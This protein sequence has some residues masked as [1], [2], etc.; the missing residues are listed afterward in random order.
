MDMQ[1]GAASTDGV[2]SGVRVLD[3]SQMLAGP[4]CGMRLGDM[5][6]DVIKIEPPGAG[7][8]TRTHSFA[9]AEINGHTTA[10]LG[11]NRNKRSVA[12]NLK[13]PRGQEILHDLVRHSDVFIQNFRVG[14]AERLGVGYEQLKAVNPKLIYGQI[15]G[16]GEEG[17]YRDRPGQDLIVQGYSGSMFS[18]GSSDYPP[19]PGA[20]WAVDT[21]AGYQMGMGIVAALLHRERSQSGQK[22]SVNMLAVAMDCQSQELV[23]AFNLGMQPERTKAPFAHAWVTA[24]YGSYR[25]SDGWINLAQVPVHILG[26]ALENGRLQQ[27]IEWSDGM[28][29]RD[30]IYQIV[31]EI[32]PT[33]TTDEWIERLDAFKLWS[34]P[35]YTYEDLE[36]DPHVLATE[37]VTEVEHPEAGVIRMPNIPVRFS[38]T[39]G[40][41]RLA[42]P[43]LGQHTGEVLRELLGYDAAHIDS[44]KADG[45]VAEASLQ[46]EAS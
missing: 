26:Q 24:P 21:M 27:M 41:V 30:E 45:A 29:F 11:L 12:V 25:T 28:V 34:G 2:L 19:L 4:I 42:P 37:M 18:V 1:G 13:D 16:Y 3:A 22:V 46:V 5:G 44:L 38:E 14:T 6:A 15:S 7:E 33:R 43:L 36:H 9:N 17:P 20:L 31:S 35:V 8:W 40:K 32:M 10:Q 39:P 23:T